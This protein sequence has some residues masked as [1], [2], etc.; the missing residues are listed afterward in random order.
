M[1]QPQGGML[2]TDA[3]VRAHPTVKR[4]IPPRE[5]QHRYRFECCWCGMVFR[6]A[7]VVFDDRECGWICRGRCARRR[8]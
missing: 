7:H 2:W 1:T 5:L 3:E 6:R 4:R 8:R